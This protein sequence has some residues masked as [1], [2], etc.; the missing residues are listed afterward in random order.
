MPP[1]LPTPRGTQSEVDGYILTAARLIA[2]QLHPGAWARGFDWCRD[3]LGAAGYGALASE[4]Q[5]AR[6][7]EHLARKEYGAA[8]ALLKEFER[9]DSRQRARA[10]VNLSALQ[11]LEGQLEAAGAYADYCCEADPGAPLA[12]V[13]RGN[14][15]LAAGQAE[16]ALQV[17][18]AGAGCCLESR[19]RCFLCNHAD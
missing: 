6:A 15:H 8:V 18:G 7:N 1:R 4:V 11:L 2:P 9:G 14:V 5:L 3:Q 16:Q 19:T 10:A 12:L 17:G 13:S